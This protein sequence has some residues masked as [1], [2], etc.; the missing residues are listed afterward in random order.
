MDDD[1]PVHS[2]IDNTDST[3]EIWPLFNDFNTIMA[4]RLDVEEG[5]SEEMPEDTD[6]YKQQ[7]TLFGDFN[8]ILDHKLDENKFD[9]NTD[10]ESDSEAVRPLFI[11]LFIYLLIIVYLHINLFTYL[12]AK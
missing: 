3:P 2:P 6:I 7:S 11:D 9:E 8:A 4:H 10:E 1:S 12:S 5:V